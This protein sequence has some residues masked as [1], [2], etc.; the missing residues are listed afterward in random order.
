MRIQNKS[1]LRLLIPQTL[2]CFFLALS[3]GAEIRAENAENA[4]KEDMEITLLEYSVRAE[5]SDRF[6]D[7][8]VAYTSGKGGYLVTLR[9][10]YAEFRIPA[11]LGREAIEKQI[12]SIPG[13]YVYR[14]ARQS[15]DASGELVDLRAKLKVAESNLAKLRELSSTAG[16]DDLLD[17]ERALTRALE[18]VEDLKG[19]INYLKESANLYSVKIRINST[20]GTSDPEKVRIPW[21][22]GLTIDGIMGDL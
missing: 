9:S 11:K 1:F 2:L 14:A 19:R 5:S 17:L 20:T 22:R 8:M 10:G 21:V 3:G 18:E 16:L 7:E 12:A 15:E 6:V 4:G 13:T